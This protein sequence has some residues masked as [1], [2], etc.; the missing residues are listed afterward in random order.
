MLLTRHSRGHLDSRSDQL[1]RGQR[2]F[3]GYQ[4][5]GWRLLCVPP[6][7][8]Y[9]V[10]ACCAASQADKATW[11]CRNVGAL[12][13]RKLSHHIMWKISR[14][15]GI[16]WHRSWPGHRLQNYTSCSTDRFTHTVQYHMHTCCNLLHAFTCVCMKS[17]Y[18]TYRLN[19]PNLRKYI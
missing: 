14:S 6:S 2:S 10:C 19:L 11:Q 7:Q 1:R 12:D 9:R 17:I 4:S 8:A 5:C 16:C 3:R 15:Q 13:T 18:S